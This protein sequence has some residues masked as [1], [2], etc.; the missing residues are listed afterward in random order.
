MKPST[1]CP[2]SQQMKHWMTHQLYQRPRKPFVFSV[3]KAPGSDSIPATVYKE[4]G[5]ALT[6]K[7]PPAVY[8]HVAAR[9]YPAG[10]QRCFNHTSVQMQRKPSVLRKPPRHLT[11]LH[12]RQDTHQDPA[13]PSHT[14]PRPGTPSTEQV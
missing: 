4:G 11:P 1:T 2:K 10:F 3:C 9:D 6:G 5:T 8:T 7:N 12:R 13:Q 14:A